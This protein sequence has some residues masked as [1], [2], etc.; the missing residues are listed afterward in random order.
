MKLT[1]PARARLG[2]AERAMRRW[3][4]MVAGAHR[5]LDPALGSV[6]LTFDDGPHPVYTPLVLD[7]LRDL[8]V[9][10]TFFVVGDRVDRHPEIVR[11]MVREGHA[12]GWHS[13]SHPDPWMLPL[14]VLLDEYREGPRAL[15]VVMDQGA[16]I[17][18]FRPPKGYLEIHHAAVTRALRLDLWLWTIDPGDWKPAATPAAILEA[19]GEPV[20]GDVILLHDAIER[21]I[22][23]E[24]LDRSATVEALPDLVT[25]VHGLGLRF[26]PL[27]NG[28][29]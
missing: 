12:I 2:A 27:A 15:A 17:R 29:P 23:E 16:P 9:P 20:A 10:A 3:A 11:R 19:L 14:R 1:Q 26:A 25:R 18:L 22:E 6:A 21:P 7:V 8:K 5:R 4:P 24:A 13:R 28:R